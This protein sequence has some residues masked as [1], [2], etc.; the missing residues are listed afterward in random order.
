M[1]FWQV[2][3]VVL[4]L[5]SAVRGAREQMQKDGLPVPEALEKAA[6]KAEQLEVVLG[7]AIGGEAKEQLDAYD[8]FL[9]RTAEMGA[10]LRLY[11]IL[12]DGSLDSD[13]DT[14][15]PDSVDVPPFVAKLADKAVDA[16]RSDP[17]AP[18]PAPESPVATDG[19]PA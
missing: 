15:L 10:G 12:A 11:R 13:P 2:L 14:G 9:D 8:R 16:V 17:P 3:Q 5:G 7:V 6:T 18:D 1:K 4:G 19:E